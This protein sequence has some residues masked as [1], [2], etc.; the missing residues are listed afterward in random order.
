MGI[1]QT[2]CATA[3]RR[4]FVTSRGLSVRPSADQ[5]R[6]GQSPIVGLCL[7]SLGGVAC[8]Q[9]FSP[10][11]VRRRTLT[12]IGRG[13]CRG[14]WTPPAGMLRACCRWVHVPPRACSMLCSRNCSKC[15][16][17][18]EHACVSR[19]GCSASSQKVQLGSIRPKN[20]LARGAGEG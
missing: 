2:Y 13:K 11:E 14:S 3:N 12:E 16:A 1:K 10:P 7:F 19:G 4:Y 8:R 15:G 18:S 5:N 20:G 9:A 6:V 17:F